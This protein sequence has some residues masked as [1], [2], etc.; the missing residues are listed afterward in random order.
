MKIDK[1][2]ERYEAYAINQNKD[3]RYRVYEDKLSL[4]KVVV[5]KLKI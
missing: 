5:P 3:G 2:R 1:N 4:R